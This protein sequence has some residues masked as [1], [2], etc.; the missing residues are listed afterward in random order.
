MTEITAKP[1]PR[2][3][4][5]EA[6]FWAGLREGEI[7]VQHCV[8]C[9]TPRFPASRFCPECHSDRAEWRAVEPR[10][11]VESHCTFHKCYFPGFV[12][13]MPYTVIQVR[14]DCGL[15]FFS[16]IADGGRPATGQ[17]VAAVF[18]PATADVVLLKFAPED[19]A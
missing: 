7:R 9:G 16:N 19:G 13:D 3:D 2:L 5:P 12:G 4:G 14:L 6:P 10:G 17:R 8:A 1:L 18:E 11:E 15:R